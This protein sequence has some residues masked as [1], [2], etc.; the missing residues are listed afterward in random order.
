MICAD[1]LLLTRDELLAAVDKP[2]HHKG[3]YEL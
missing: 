1:V 2:Q 3:Y